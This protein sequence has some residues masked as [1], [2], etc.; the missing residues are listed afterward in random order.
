[1]VKEIFIF[2]WWKF[3]LRVFTTIMAAKIFTNIRSLRM[4]SIFTNISYKYEKED[5]DKL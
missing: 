2:Y 5:I 4:K 1:M 3:L